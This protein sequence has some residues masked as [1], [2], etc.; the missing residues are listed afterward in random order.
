MLQIKFYILHDKCG[1]V[2]L[3]KTLNAVENTL[4]Y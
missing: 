4:N 3:K 2:I 1:M